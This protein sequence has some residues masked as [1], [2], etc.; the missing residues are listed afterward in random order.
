MRDSAR[1]RIGAFAMVGAG[2]VVTRDCAAACIGGGRAGE[3]GAAGL[4]RCGVGLIEEQATFWGCRQCGK[5]YDPHMLGGVQ[6]PNGPAAD[7]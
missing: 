3:A 2:A 6:I 5:T 1:R 4:C 7:R